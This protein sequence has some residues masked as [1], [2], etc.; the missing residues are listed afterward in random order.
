MSANLR[1]IIKLVLGTLGCFALLLALQVILINNN[2]RIDLTP[3]KK[4][5]LSP[6]TEQIVKNL[7][8]DVQA[9][10]FINSDRPENF[11]VED[12]MWRM[13]TLSKRFHHTI[14]DMNRNPAL[15]R[16]YNAV[17]Y[18][19]LVFES[20]GQRKGTL[21][22]SGESA[23]AS[24][25][26]QVT[27]KKEKTIYFLTGHGEGS[28][29]NNVPQ[30]GY[31][32]LRG[33]IFDETY[34]EK[35]L[36]LAASNGVPDDADVVVILGPKGPFMPTELSALDV[37]VQRGGALFVLLDVNGSPSLVPFLE[38]YNIYL[39]DVV[40]VD[41]AKRLYAGE[42]IT[43]RVSATAKPH[44]MLLSVNAPPIFSLA[45]VVEVRED[46]AKGMIAR[47]ILATSGEGF[48]TASKN[49]SQAGTATFVA[50]RDISGP[51]PIAGEV[52]FKKDEKLGRIAVFGDAD[53][54]NNSLLDQGGNRDLFVNAIN[55]LAEDEEILGERPPRETP[56][57]TTFILTDTDGRWLLTMSTVVL[58]GLFFLTG[59]AVFLW[60][61]QHG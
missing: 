35:P 56:F 33:A 48:A 45:R 57:V 8:K 40:A 52:A 55:W 59:V 10:A 44:P 21:L 17:Q 37:Y 20:D 22:S 38:Q 7:Q 9:L 58:P 23:V 13:A 42:I 14:I 36:S 29:D 28:L 5:T 15:A 39:P 3:E 60:R 1:N 46:L 49:I 16:Q 6:R 27:R 25:L 31:S 53:M 12:M 54:L 4:F 18:G 51:V 61:R 47:P 24:T 50:E 30:D 2:H 26:L 34:H 41:P 19:T 11:F 32:K 43:Y